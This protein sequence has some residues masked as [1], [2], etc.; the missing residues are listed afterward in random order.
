MKY[1]KLPFFATLGILFLLSLILPAMISDG[2]N[3]NTLADYATFHTYILSIWGLLLNIYLVYIAFKAYQNFD[4][5]KQYHNKQLD[6]V[7]NLSNEISSTILSNMMHL[8]IEKETGEESTALT[9]LTYSV[10]EMALLNYSKYDLMC[11][12]GN[13]IE[14]TFP[15]LKYRK[16]PILPKSIARQLNKLYRPFQYSFSINN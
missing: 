1:L 12:R 10:F 11:V 3:F 9:G 15:F 7:T 14:N 5:K 8:T 6:V 4:V 16:N 2:D 13:N